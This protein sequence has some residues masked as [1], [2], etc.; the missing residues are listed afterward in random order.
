M[1]TLSATSTTSPNMQTFE[2]QELLKDIPTRQPPAIYVAGP[3]TT[4]AHGPYIPIGEAART[5]R[6]LF[7]LGWLPFVPQLN[8]IWEMAAGELVEGKG[9][10]GWLEYDFMQIARQD[11]LY[12]LDGPSKGADREVTLAHKLHIPVFFEKRTNGIQARSPSISKWELVKR[13]KARQY[14]HYSA[15]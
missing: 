13:E 3:M 6:D 5:A 9:T 8:S 12:R 11:A 4:G 7:R 14:G 15:C 1:A 10:E 2:I